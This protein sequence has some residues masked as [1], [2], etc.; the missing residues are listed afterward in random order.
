M[1]KFEM[2]LLELAKKEKK[3]IE[4]VR[5]IKN[6]SQQLMMRF[7][8]FELFSPILD[9]RSAENF[10]NELTKR[11]EISEIRISRAVRVSDGILGYIVYGR[12]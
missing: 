3:D 4:D 6:L 10:M 9:A 1:E 12:K 2:K 7:K 8:G 11:N 5:A